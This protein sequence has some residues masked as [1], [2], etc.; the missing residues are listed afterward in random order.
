MG[1]RQTGL[2]SPAGCTINCL[3]YRLA[4]FKCHRDFLPSASRRFLYRFLD[5]MDYDAFITLMDSNLKS[6]LSV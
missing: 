6:L 1:T 2:L 4:E 5:V 3:L